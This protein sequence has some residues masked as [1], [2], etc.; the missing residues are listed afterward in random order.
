MSILALALASPSYATLVTSTNNAD[1]IYNVNTTP[2]GPSGGGSTSLTATIEFSNFTFTT[3]AGGNTVVTFTTAVD[4]TTQQGTL[5]NSQW[6]SIRLTAFGYD[7]DPTAIAGSDNSS[8]YNTFLDTNFPSFHQVDVCL[9]SGNKSCAGGA[10]GGLS[11]SGT[12]T[13]IETL[14]FSGGITSF[15]FG[16]GPNELLST[17]WQTGFGSFETSTTPG[18]LDC[19]PTPVIFAPEP[20]SLGMLGSALIAFT[21][22][23]WWRRRD[24]P[25][26]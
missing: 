16:I 22:W 19:V 11:P 25:T 26:A 8:V 23:M 20:G 12:D 15:D 7:V 10:N 9:S 17:K 21:G 18:C 13:F 6:Q 4:N 14:T 1:I 2:V 24:N 3:N 5:T